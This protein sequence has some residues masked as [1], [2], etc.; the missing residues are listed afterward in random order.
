MGWY[1]SRLGQGTGAFLDDRM[2]KG[3]TE[4]LAGRG[5]TNGDIVVR[6]TD[7]SKDIAVSAR[8][9]PSPCSSPCYFMVSTVRMGIAKA[10]YPGDLHVPSTKIS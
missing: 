3:E 9:R 1:R 10:K 7:C 8:G 6:V 4:T 5:R 2:R